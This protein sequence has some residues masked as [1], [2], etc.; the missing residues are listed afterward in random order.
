MSSVTITD[1]LGRQ[2]GWTW[3]PT[4]SKSWQSVGGAQTLDVLV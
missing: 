4:G 1:T 2:Y 3:T